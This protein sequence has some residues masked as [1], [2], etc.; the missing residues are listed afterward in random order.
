MPGREWDEGVAVPENPERGG[1]KSRTGRRSNRAVVRVFYLLSWFWKPR[2]IV[3]DRG[4]SMDSLQMVSHWD[5]VRN[6]RHEFIPVQVG[7]LV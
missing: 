1:A 5:S 6:L 2:T 4:A 7:A 3:F